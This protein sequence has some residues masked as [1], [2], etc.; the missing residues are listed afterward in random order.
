LDGI[1]FFEKYSREHP[2]EVLCFFD[3]MEFPIKA[4]KISL[5]RLKKLFLEVVEQDK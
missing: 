3:W 4:H 2:E 1:D 5:D